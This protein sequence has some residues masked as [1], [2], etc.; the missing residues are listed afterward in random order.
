MMT[1][2][3]ATAGVV[4]TLGTDL[5]ARYRASAVVGSEQLQAMVFA[6]VGTCGIA[7][8]TV[9]GVGFVWNSLVGKKYPA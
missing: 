6:Y 2:V 1:S 5:G 9:V 8:T 4:S 3:G 7:A